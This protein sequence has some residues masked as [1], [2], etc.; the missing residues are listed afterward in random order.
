[1]RIFCMIL[2]VFLSTNLS[3]QKRTDS[4]STDPPRYLAFQFSIEGKYD[5]AI[6]YYNKELENLSDTSDKYWKYSS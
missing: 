5:S 2:L 3:A 1:M 4:L 6:Y